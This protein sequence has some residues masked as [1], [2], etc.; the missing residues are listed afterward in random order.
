MG[1]FFQ[2]E[3]KTFGHVLDPRTGQPA[4]SACLAAVVLPSATETDALST[5]LLV[6]GAD[7]HGKIA[8]LRFGMR[9]LLVTEAEGGLRIEGRGIQPEER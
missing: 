6:L 5:A 3:G 2:A 1:R 7:G 8:K 9:T 4:A